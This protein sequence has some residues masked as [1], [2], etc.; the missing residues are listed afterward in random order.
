MI[1]LHGYLLVSAALFCIGAAGFIARRNLFAI[2]MSLEL[3][4]NAIN[5][6]LVAFSRHWLELGGQVMVLL[7]VAVAAAEAAIALAAVIL[8]FRNKE[9]LDSDAFRLLKE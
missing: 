5:L 4:L 8:L 1:G 3:M 6:S 7:L 9:T 2:L